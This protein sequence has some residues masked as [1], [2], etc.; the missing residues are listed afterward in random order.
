MAIRLN[1]RAG[2][3]N[4]V[5]IF[6]AHAEAVILERHQIANVAFTVAYAGAHG[7]PIALGQFK[8]FD[9]KTERMLAKGGV[10]YGCEDVDYLIGDGES[11]CMR[12]RWFPCQRQTSIGHMRNNWPVGQRCWSTVPFVLLVI[13]I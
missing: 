3:A 10:K 9:L 13:G 5:L 2:I 7:D 1:I 11:G 8:L 4:A 12:H 6:Y